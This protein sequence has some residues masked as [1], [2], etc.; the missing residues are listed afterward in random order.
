MV[1]L[2]FRIRAVEQGLRPRKRT[3]DDRGRQ[4]QRG[5]R[6]A[7][8]GQRVLPDQEELL[9]EVKGP[10]MMTFYTTGTCGDV[11]HINVQWG[12]KQRGFENAA[13][14]GIILAGEV[15]RTFPRY[16]GVDTEVRFSD[17]TR[18]AVDSTHIEREGG[19]L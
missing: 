16:K 8:Q 18:G 10:G 3:R 9:G 15:L 11:N 6:Q 1:E 17:G 13:R 5:H 2:E 12:E 19:A 4:R 7:G 14:M